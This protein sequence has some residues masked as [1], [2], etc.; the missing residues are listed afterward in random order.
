MSSTATGSPSATAA[1]SKH[2]TVECDVCIGMTMY[3][4]AMRDARQKPMCIGLK[5]TKCEIDQ[6]GFVELLEKRQQEAGSSSAT[7]TASIRYDDQQA[8]L[9]HIEAF[10][11]TLSNKPHPK[12]DA[13]AHDTIYAPE[14]DT[15]RYLYWGMTLYSNPAP[16]SPNAAAGNAKLVLPL[17][18]GISYLQRSKQPVAGSATSPTLPTTSPIQRSSPLVLEHDGSGPGIL[19]KAV[20]A[21]NFTAMAMVKYASHQATNFPERYLQS[22]ERLVDN[23]QAQW[24]SMSKLAIRIVTLGGS[25]KDS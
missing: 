22:M 5:S 1:A 20:A 9:H 14:N 13:T 2:P 12:V 24:D 7:N 4:S 10:L 3:T 16:T 15:F 6:Q 23:M 21:C 25:K 11:A 17:C 18:V 19:D 8:R